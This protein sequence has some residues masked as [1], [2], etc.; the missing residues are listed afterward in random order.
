[1]V[2]KLQERIKNDDYP[3]ENKMTHALEKM[4]EGGILA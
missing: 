3:I 4:Y 2:E 1:M